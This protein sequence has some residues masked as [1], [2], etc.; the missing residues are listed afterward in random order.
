MQ[1]H[2]AVHLRMRGEDLLEQR[3]SS[4]RQSEDEDGIRGIAAELAALL[5]QVRRA[6]LDLLVD[7]ARRV[8]GIVAGALQLERI[9]TGVVFERR[10]ELATVFERLANRKAQMYSVVDGDPRARLDILHVV[11]IIVVEPVGLGIREAPEC[12]AIIGLFF[13]GGAV[14]DNGGIEGTHGLVRMPQ[15]HV[16]P[17]PVG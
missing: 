7:E 14:G 15:H 13:A 17:S 6:C 4:A 5:E 3:R 1:L 11:E 16:H 10:L 2:R 9:A 8:L 12:V